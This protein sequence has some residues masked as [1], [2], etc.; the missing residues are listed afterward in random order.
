[1]IERVGRRKMF[2]IGSAGQAIAM[3]ITMAGVAK[4]THEA[5]KASV[6]GMFL[7]LVFFGATWLELPWLYPGKSLLG[8]PAT[9]A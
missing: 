1:M 4:G 2:L 5:L 8:Q 9:T 7:Y 6:F 3:F